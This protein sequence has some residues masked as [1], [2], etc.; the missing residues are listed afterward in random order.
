MKRI[1]S[2]CLEMTITFFPKED[3]GPAAAAHALKEEL[4]HYKALLERNHTKYKILEEKE[5]PDH[6]VTLKL[7]KQYNNYSCKGYI[8]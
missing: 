4:T 8:E 3:T 5:M 2:A 7:K 1:Q 6:S